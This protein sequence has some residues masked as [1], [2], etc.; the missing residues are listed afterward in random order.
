M[1]SFQFLTPIVF[2]FQ[3][4]AYVPMLKG[5]ATEELMLRTRSVVGIDTVLSFHIES[6]T[7]MS[8]LPSGLGMGERRGSDSWWII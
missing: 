8:T 6:V 1:R 5:P 4:S 7:S 3:L 2:K